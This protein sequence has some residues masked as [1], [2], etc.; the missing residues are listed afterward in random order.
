M[1]VYVVDLRAEGEQYDTLS[2][3]TRQMLTSVARRHSGVQDQADLDAWVTK[4][5]LNDVN[6]ILSKLRHVVEA[7]VQNEWWIDR[8]AIQAELPDH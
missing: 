8:E 4:L 5:E 2:V 7:L 1:A 6:G 3:T